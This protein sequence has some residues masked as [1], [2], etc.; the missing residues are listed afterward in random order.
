MSETA[1]TITALV[2]LHVCVLLLY[3]AYLQRE[4]CCRYH[5]LIPEVGALGIP[6]TINFLGRDL[7]A[8]FMTNYMIVCNHSLGSSHQIMSEF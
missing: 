1:M 3:S 4:L 2:L 8:G 5:L 7:L 6:P